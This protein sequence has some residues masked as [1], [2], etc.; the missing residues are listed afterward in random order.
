MLPPEIE[1]ERAFRLAAYAIQQFAV[2]GHGFD[3][4]LHKNVFHSS[5]TSKI[6]SEKFD[7]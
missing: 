6:E 1:R 4:I 7:I 2:F 5:N 3:Q